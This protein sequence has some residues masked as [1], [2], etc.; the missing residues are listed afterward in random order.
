MTNA[1][2]SS[3]LKTNLSNAQSIRE[4]PCSH[5]DRQHQQVSCQQDPA[6]CAVGMKKNTRKETKVPLWSQDTFMFRLCRFGTTGSQHKSVRP[7]K[8]LSQSFD[9]HPVEPG[10]SES[11]S[12]H[13]VSV[14]GSSAPQQATKPGLLTG[15]LEGSRTS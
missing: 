13:T 14:A 10:K 2:Q 12:E 6:A 11:L 5:F 15:A 7:N 3:C 8:G 9:S 1:Q 4:M